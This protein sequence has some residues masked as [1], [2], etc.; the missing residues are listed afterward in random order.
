M[1]LST[2]SETHGMHPLNCHS[3][4]IMQEE[5]IYIFEHLKD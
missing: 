2:P 5:N 1:G 4:H 3:A